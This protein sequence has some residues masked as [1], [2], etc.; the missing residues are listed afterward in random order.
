MSD[1]LK[2]ADRSFADLLDLAQ[3]RV[4]RTAPADASTAYTLDAVMKRLFDPQ[5]R[6]L[7]TVSAFGSAL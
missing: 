7:V 3:V 2:L 1:L 6:D 4:A 5:E